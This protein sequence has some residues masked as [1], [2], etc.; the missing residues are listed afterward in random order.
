MI[1]NAYIYRLLKAKQSST[2]IPHTF[3]KCI[4]REA[5]KWFLVKASSLTRLE[6][7]T[8]GYKKL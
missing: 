3:D 4:M 2:L 6:V 5:T 8:K 7:L 1:D